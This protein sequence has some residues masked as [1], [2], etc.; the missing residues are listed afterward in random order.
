ME[1][2]RRRGLADV[3]GSGSAEG[4][5][6]PRPSPSSLAK[7][8]RGGGRGRNLALAKFG[9]AVG[10]V[11]AAED[12]S[13]RIRSA[14]DQVQSTGRTARPSARSIR[15]DSR[16]ASG[17]LL[18][19]ARSSKRV[20]DGTEAGDVRALRAVPLFTPESQVRSDSPLE[21]TGFEPVWAF[22]SSSGFWFFA[23]SLFGAG[24]PFFVL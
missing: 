3:A 13:A 11:L 18:E 8:S 9:A 12:A 2:D 20:P 23:G 19:A 10:Q 15:R 16:A 7:A 14:S 1:R 22:L 24:K 6:R 17:R 5:S 21:G 4:D